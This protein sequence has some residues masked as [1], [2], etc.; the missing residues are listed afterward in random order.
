M[1]TGANRGI[2]KALVDAYLDSGWTI[3]AACRDPASAPEGTRAMALDIGDEASVRALVS[4]LGNEPIDVL[5][6]NA[7]V[8]VDKGKSLDEN[9]YADWELSFRINTAGPVHLASLLRN[10]VAASSHKTM[11]FTSSN[12]GSIANN[13]GGS[14]LYRSS[15]SALNMAVDC[16]SKELAPS[17]VKTV[18]FHPGWVIT[19]MGGEDADI[20]TTTSA[21]GMKKVVDGL[22][23]SGTFVNYDGRPLPW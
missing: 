3:I 12:M 15:K 8:Y 1:I 20:D 2:G 7:G 19:E 23:Q 18:L 6:N 11:A 16:L 21:I 10:N 13:K 22:S 9:S 4:S 14:Y 5:W 17:G